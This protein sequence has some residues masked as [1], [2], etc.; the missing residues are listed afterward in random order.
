M[1]HFGNLNWTSRHEIKIVNKFS[2]GTCNS[3][4]H[5]SVPFFASREILT[6]PIP[7]V[8]DSLNQHRSAQWSCFRTVPRFF[9]P[10]WDFSKLFSFF[11]CLFRE[12]SSFFLHLIHNLQKLFFL[13]SSASERGRE[14]FAKTADQ[15]EE[16]REERTQNRLRNYD[17]H[18]KFF[19]CFFLRRINL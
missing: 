5:F 14:K 6:R 15:W 19:F 10:R 12:F 7:G 16:N 2:S 18:W 9:L 8:L 4:I 1:K 17:S 13:L 11:V 3:Y